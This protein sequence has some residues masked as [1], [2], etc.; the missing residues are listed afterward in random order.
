MYSDPK[1]WKFIQ[2]SFSDFSFA[3]DISSL[4]LPRDQELSS[5]SNTSPSKQLWGTLSLSR[6]PLISNL[7]NAMLT[8]YESRTPLKNIR[9]ASWQMSYFHRQLNWTATCA[10]FKHVNKYCKVIEAII[11]IYETHLYCYFPWI[12]TMLF[13]CRRKKKDFKKNFISKSLWCYLNRD[14]FSAF[15]GCTTSKKLFKNISTL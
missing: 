6:P 12:Y 13:S 1:P 8:F 14:M 9:F 10:L 4:L 5:Q 11:R 15:L 7:N 3:V 2:S